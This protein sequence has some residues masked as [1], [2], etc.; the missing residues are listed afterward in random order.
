M[1]TTMM[2]LIL[3][4]LMGLPCNVVAMIAI[5]VAAALVADDDDDDDDQHH[6]GS[7]TLYHDD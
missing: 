1:M 2:L 7:R 5:S 3:L 6:D 4:P